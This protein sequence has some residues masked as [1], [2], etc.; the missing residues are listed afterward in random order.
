MA[1]LPENFYDD[2]ISL[3]EQEFSLTGKPAK[4]GGEEEED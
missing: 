3:M 4:I 2:R 1:I